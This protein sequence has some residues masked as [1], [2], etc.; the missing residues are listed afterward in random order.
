VA[1]RPGVDNDFGG[2]HRRVFGLCADRAREQGA[3]PVGGQCRV[4]CENYESGCLLFER[5]GGRF[6]PIHRAVPLALR[7]GENRRGSA[8]R[9][10]RGSNRSTRVGAIRDRL[11]PVAPQYVILWGGDHV[12]VPLLV[13]S[14]AVPA[15]ALHTL[16]IRIGGAKDQGIG[17]RH[18]GRTI[19][20][21]Q[22]S[23][24]KTSSTS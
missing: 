5:R 11:K 24:S 8:S 4:L 18:R 2:V 22:K 7:G 20:A 12:G 17:P 15:E 23:A 10:A 19:E 3:G 9:T 21:W 16:P 13:S 1:A 14:S 6:H